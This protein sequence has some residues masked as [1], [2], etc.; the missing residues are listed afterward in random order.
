MCCKRL[1]G[2]TGCKNDAKNCHLS[3]IAQLCWAISSQLRHVSTIWKKLVKQHYLPH[4]WSN[5]EFGHPC[6]FQRVSRLGS[7]TAQHSLRRWTEGATY[8]RLGGHHVRHWPTFLVYLND[9]GIV[10]I[11]KKDASWCYALSLWRGWICRLDKDDSVHWSMF[12]CLCPLCRVH[13]I[14]LQQLPPLPPPHCCCN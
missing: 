13:W 9:M 1:A 4:M 11:T 8:I 2:K 3:T 5:G 7:V 6:K 10:C 14:E 12:V